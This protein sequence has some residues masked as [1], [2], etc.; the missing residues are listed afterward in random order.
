MGENIS[1]QC[2]WQDLISKIYKQLTQLNNNKKPNQ[3]WAEEL[4]RH[5]NKDK[6]TAQAQEKMLNIAN[7]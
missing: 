7:H 2:N 3:K 5:F 4:N 1:I 6:Q